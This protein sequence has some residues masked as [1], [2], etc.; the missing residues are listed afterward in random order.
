MKSVNEQ[1]VQPQVKQHFSWFQFFGSFFTLS[2]LA[3]LPGI[4]YGNNWHLVLTPLLGWYLLYWALVAAGFSAFTAWQK[5]RA[6]DKPLKALSDAAEQVANGNFDVY[7]Q[8][9]H[10]PQNYDYLDAM[11]ANFNIMVAE[12]GSTETL[13]SDFVAN[14]SHEFKRPLA[15]IQGYA[16][17][18]QQSGLDRKTQQLYLTT[19]SDSV[20][21]LATLVTNI[22]KLN[23]L[24][25][26]VT[27]PDYQKFDLSAQLTRCLLDD[28]NAIDAKQLHL[29][30]DLPDSLPIIS[31]PQLLEIVWHNLIG[32]AIKFAP[33]RGHLSILA[34]ADDTT[35][36]VHIHDDGQGIDENTQAHIFDKFYQ[37][38]TSHA[39]AG[40][41]LGLAIVAQVIRLP[42]AKISVQ[43]N[44][45]QGT[46][47]TVSLPQSEN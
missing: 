33:P 22:L 14:V 1:A 15:N 4:L 47:F 17:A 10:A 16:Q 28:A 30:I 27:A 37:G 24:Q 12:L 7:L 32:N 3:A 6:F 21:H 39:S 11:F 46:T 44:P 13:R 35:L 31:N 8:P 45:H 23:K 18:L 38:D 34:K 26:Q 9:V 43:S 36:R 5:Y 19:I 29:T 20:A 25:T 41:G 42:N 2:I 40:N